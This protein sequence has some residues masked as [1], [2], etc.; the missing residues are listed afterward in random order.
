MSDLKVIDFY[1]DWCG[2]CKVLTPLIE[3]LK[4]KNPD[5]AI[6]KVNVD[7]NRDLALTFS[8]RSIP[9]VIFLKGDEE[10]A[11]EVGVKQES[12]YQ[13]LIDQHK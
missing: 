10:I 1:A 8:V 11:R 13:E 12:Y 6:E 7:E 4:D 5:V 3:K 9:T 2:P